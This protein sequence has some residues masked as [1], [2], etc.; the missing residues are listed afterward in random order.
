[1]RVIT[2]AFCVM[3]APSPVA[4]QA[5][6]VGGIEIQLGQNISDAV[7]SLS[8]YK[9]R[10]SDEGKT[11]IVTQA[12]KDPFEL[13]GTLHA[14]AGRVTGITKVYHVSSQYDT[15][16][17]YTQAAQEVRRRGGA[18]CEMREVEYTDN[19]IH[20][21]ETRCGFYRLIYSFASKYQEDNV[22]AGVAIRLSRGD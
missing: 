8:T 2:A 21:I 17:V 18:I 1:M 6:D 13:I 16:R 20:D 10:Y 4:A 5:L 7:K 22:A 19:Q 12:G 14:T 15:Q 3:I 11:W 9:V